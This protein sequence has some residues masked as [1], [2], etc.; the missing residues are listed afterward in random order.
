MLSNFVRS[1]IL[2][3]WGVVPGER[4]HMVHARQV[5]RQRCREWQHQGAHPYVN[6]G[7]LPIPTVGKVS[8]LRWLDV[9]PQPSRRCPGLR[10]RHWLGIRRLL[11]K[12]LR[13]P[14]PDLD[15]LIQ[16]G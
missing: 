6:Q 2:R 11:V 4:H 12:E 14:L 5:V 3:T 7:V 1:T 13:P 8:I 16:L 9:Q 15:S 10:R